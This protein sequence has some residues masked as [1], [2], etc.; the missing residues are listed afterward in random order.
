MNILR[1]GGVEVTQAGAPFSAEGKQYGAGSYV[2]VLG[3][4]YGPFAK[5]LLEVQHYPNIAPVSGRPRCSARTTSPRKHLPLLMGVAADAV[6]KPFTVQGKPVTRAETPVSFAHSDSGYLL[7]PSV[8]N[9][10]AVL[11]GLLKAGIKGYRLTSGPSKPGTIFIPGGPGVDARL[12]PLVTAFPITLHAAPAGLAGGAMAVTLP[13]IA[14][15][16]SWVPSM[17]EG[18][19]RWLF[20]TNGIPYTRLVDADMRHGGL[21]DRFDVIVLPDEPAGL[22]LHGAGMRREGNDDPPTPPRVHRR[23]GRSRCRQ[24]EELRRSRRHGRRAQQGF[25]GLC[26]QGRAGQG[27][28]R[29]RRRQGLLRARFHPR[30]RRRPQRSC[31]LRLRGPATHILRAKPPPSTRKPPASIRSPASPATT[32]C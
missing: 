21:K 6:S 4:P 24:P 8:N 20:D 28:A 32:P 30:S 18:W 27:R 1:T 29:R 26:Q 13:R 12:A 3:Q 17:D 19:T 22:I 2:V 31:R 7:D 25:R 14:M 23:P 5:T 11:F 15:Y 10:Y 16:Q 9:S